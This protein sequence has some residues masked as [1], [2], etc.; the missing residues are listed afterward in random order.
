MSQFRILFL[1]HVGSVMAGASARGLTAVDD[2]NK[3]ASTFLLYA[4]HGT[5][6]S[7]ELLNYYTV[8]LQ[9]AYKHCFVS[10]WQ[11]SA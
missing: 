1:L 6:T 8:R 11:L 9:S 4:L 5:N 7:P 10:K 3:E 2:K